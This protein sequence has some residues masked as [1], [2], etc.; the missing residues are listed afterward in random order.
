M[1]AGGDG[2]ICFR[3]VLL[4]NTIVI[5]TP[6]AW[7]CV[8]V[9]AL[10]C[11]GLP[12]SVARAQRLAV[13][14]QAASCE[15]DPDGKSGLCGR[16]MSAI[17]GMDALAAGN[18]IPAAGQGDTDITHCFLDIEINPTSQTVLGSNTLDIT[19]TTDG[20]NQ[21][22]LDLRS[23][24]I[25]DSVIV[26]AFAATFSRPTN[27]ILINLGRSYAAGESFQV[28]VLYHGTPSNLGWQSFRFSSHGSPSQ[29]IVCS[30]SEP[31][32]AHTWWPC[33][34]SQVDNDDKFTLD[35]WVTVPGT[36]TVASNGRLL[37]TDTLSGSRKRFRWQEGHPIATY[38][39]SVAATNY[40]KVTYT[41]TFPGGSMPVELYTYPERLV[42]DQANTADLVS[43]IATLSS[44]GA[45]GQ[46][47]F[48]DEKYGIAR[49]S[50]CCGMEHQTITSQ[51]SIEW[52]SNIHEL[53][54]QWWG[55]M[56]T[57][58]SW[59]DIWL[60]EGFASFSEA[61]WLERKPGGSKA[62]YHD[63][64]NNYRMPGD[65]S[66][67]VY[68]SDIS[69]YSRIF[70][71]NLSYKKG[72]WVL[73]MLRHV[74]GDEVFFQVLANYRAAYQYAAADTEQFKAIAESTSG[75]ELD[76]F[77][78]AWV[79]GPG[80]PSY[81]HGWQQVQI[82]SQNWVRAYIQ[83]YQVIYGVFKMPLDVTI[84]TAA[85][86]TTTPAWNEH[87]AQWYLLPAGGTVT[88][89]QFDPDNWILKDADQSVA[90]VNGPPKLVSAVPAPGT[91]VAQ[92]QSVSAIELQFSEPITW[93][94]SDFL[95]TGSTAGPQGFTTTYDAGNY[96]MTLS[97]AQPLPGGQTW[98]VSIAD[99]LRSSAA[100]A[101]LDGEVADPNDAGSLPSGDGA[102]GG[103][104]LFSFGT[105]VDLPACHNPRVDVDGDADVDMSDF[106]VFQ[107]CLTGGD[108][109]EG[110]FDLYRCHCMDLDADADVDEVDWGV[111]Q[112]CLSGAD[113]PADPA[114]DE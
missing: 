94:T 105:P 61:L 50:W 47:P 48:V 97:F 35:M 41:Y 65:T 29:P 4:E 60:N 112:A 102:P 7:T 17:A 79:Y 25:V 107:A 89:V 75:R 72:A 20:L 96:K 67:T 59:H 90:Y 76:W 101:A 62:A 110:T 99:S 70:S 12:G 43:M 87:A 114:C 5:R 53:A 64:M 66:G 27:Q 3:T 8:L 71:Q 9:S 2:Q 44:P 30:L 55:D 21:L 15:A 85:G 83:Q 39:V 98:T 84:A 77:F 16:A 51:G 34:E 37:G 42:S 46:Y 68:C 11:L 32:W 73:H 57:C 49:F 1:A 78:D 40:Q 88:S 80:A 13:D 28:R 45:Y 86:S 14:E 18:P 6:P 52:R 56:V 23:N 103:A 24:M 93:S 82:G 10:L 92:G 100:A 26:N 74:L 108:D 33:K 31:W 95:V 106:G 69:S 81:R 38:L 104:A 111:F 109:P 91:S 63:H 58:R 22:T 113:L 36:L 19:S 54:H